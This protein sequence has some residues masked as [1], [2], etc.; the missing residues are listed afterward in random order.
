MKLLLVEDERE[1]SKAIVK[2]LKLNNYSVDTAFDGF[3][4][5]D[6][7]NCENYDGIILDI[8]MPK[9]NGIEVLRKLRIAGDNT[10]VLLLTAKAEIE[11]KV[12]GLDNGADDYLAKPF[13]MKELLARIRA[14]T[15]RQSQTFQ[16]YKLGNTKLNQQTFEIETEIGKIYLTNKEYQILEMLMR[17][18]NAL[19][20]SEKF[21]Q[22]IWS[23]ET[24][25]DINVVWV[26]LS[27]LRKKL[28]S[29]KSNIKIKA[30]RS[31]GYKLEVDDG[32]KTS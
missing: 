29:I 26:Y 13:A 9:L 31:I 11:D 1:I 24:D 22:N 30:I 4:A 18:S 2:I 15:R 25:A 3:E 10:P 21:L 5:L 20:S 23:F 14:M 19:I 7:V 32:K 12:F 27:S 8:M 17:N 28:K 6:F 16:N